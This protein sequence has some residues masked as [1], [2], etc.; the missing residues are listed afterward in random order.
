MRLLVLAAA[1]V[2]AAPVAQAQTVTVEHP[3]ARATAAHAENG[4][5]YV[6][7]TAGTADRLTGASTPVAAT[8]QVHEILHDNGIMRMREVDG[9]LAL[10]AGKPV[11]LAPGGYHLMLIGLK[12]QLKRGESFPLTLSFTN[13]PAVT[14]SVP[15][16]AAGAGGAPMD[17]MHMPN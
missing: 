7:L 15:V 2:L 11:T 16:T 1:L 12:Q 13:E 17:H 14:V 8:V 5:A 4:A 6:T 9:G 10:E 3:W